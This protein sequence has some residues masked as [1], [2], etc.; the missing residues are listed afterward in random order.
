MAKPP[1]ILTDKREL[2]EVTVQEFHPQSSN[3]P[4][5]PSQRMAVII[6]TEDGRV[7]VSEISGGKYCLEIHQ[8]L[9]A[10]E[11]N[12]GSRFRVSFITL[13]RGEYDA[14]FSGLKRL[15]VEG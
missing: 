12:H 10:E 1:K 5:G 8:E 7:I 15:Q 2:F 3:R 4:I 9:P 13:T 11:D 14:L 6:E